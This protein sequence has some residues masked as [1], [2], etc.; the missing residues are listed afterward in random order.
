MFYALLNDLFCQNSE[1][2]FDVLGQITHGH[3]ALQ[4]NRYTFRKQWKIIGFFLLF[5][6]ASANL[7]QNQPA[8]PY[9][10]R[11]FQTTCHDWPGNWGGALHGIPRASRSHDEECCCG[12]VG[13]RGRDLWPDLALFWLQASW[14]GLPVQV[15]VFVLFVFYFVRKNTYKFDIAVYLFILFVHYIVFKKQTNIELGLL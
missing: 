8:F 10:V 12:S 2:S 4:M 5:S 7:H 9:T 3:N 14:K 6:G 13:R 1:N 15:S 11:H